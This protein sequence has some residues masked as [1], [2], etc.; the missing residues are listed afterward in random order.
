MKRRVFTDEERA[1]VIA[2]YQAG[3]TCAEI[4]SARDISQSTVN[5]WV[6]DAGLSRPRAWRPAPRPCTIEGCTEK[7]VAR[8]YC[9]THYGRIIRGHEPRGVVAPF[10]RQDRIEDCRWMAAGG[11]SL[12][13]AAKRIGITTNALET[14][15]RKH[16][17]DTLRP[18]LARDVVP[19]ESRATFHGVAS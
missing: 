12:T 11:E 9:R 5:N 19:M 6:R 16:D 14:W 3:K 15:L 4:A 18:L 8:G 17:P 10:N 13:G 1:S 2:D 7:H